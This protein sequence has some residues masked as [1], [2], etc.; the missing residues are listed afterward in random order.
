MADSLPH[1]ILV[2]PP[3]PPCNHTLHGWLTVLTFG[4]WAPVWMLSALL[5]RR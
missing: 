2:T 4:L 5:H 1:Y 3:R